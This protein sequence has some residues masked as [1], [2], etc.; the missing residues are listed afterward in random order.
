ML[1]NSRERLLAVLKHKVPDQIPWSSLITKYFLVSQEEGY[2]K[3]D[4]VDF[5]LEI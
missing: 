4:P 1:T 5:L 3:M 2:K